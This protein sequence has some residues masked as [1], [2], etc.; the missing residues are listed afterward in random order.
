MTARTTRE[1]DIDNL[2]YWS[3]IDI[4]QYDRHDEEAVPKCEEPCL[5]GQSDNFYHEGSC[6]RYYHGI[7]LGMFEIV[8]KLLQDGII[9][10]TKALTCI[11]F[12]YEEQMELTEIYLKE[13]YDYGGG[14][15]DYIDNF[16]K[17]GYEIG[18]T[19]ALIAIYEKKFIN[20]EQARLYST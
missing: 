12:T 8:R 11:D 2:S 10:L 3:D 20:D 16:F 17:E 18:M 4:Y 15:V 7:R 1:S 6:K 19:H 5:G 13:N 9:S 14:E